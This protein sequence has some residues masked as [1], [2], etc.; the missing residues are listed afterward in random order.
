[1]F[2]A[3]NRRRLK[4][5]EFALESRPSINSQF[6]PLLDC[7]Q[8]VEPANRASL[9][10]LLNQSTLDGCEMRVCIEDVAVERVR[11]GGMEE[12]DEQPPCVLCARERSAVIQ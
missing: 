7:R 6:T 9:V 1:M 10:Q 8:S 11:G 2:K 3:A 5:H 4:E 12:C